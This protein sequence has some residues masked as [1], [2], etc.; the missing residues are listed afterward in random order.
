MKTDDACEAFLLKSGCLLVSR[1][2]CENQESTSH[3]QR[4]TVVPG[5]VK[6]S[7]SIWVRGFPNCWRTLTAFESTLERG[8]P[9]RKGN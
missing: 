7:A 2:V 8:S 3:A 6:P 1:L 9:K 5:H 4:V